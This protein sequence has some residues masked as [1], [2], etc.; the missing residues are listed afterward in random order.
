METIVTKREGVNL[1]RGIIEALKKIIKKDSI[2]YYQ[3]NIID[4]KQAFAIK[5]KGYTVMMEGK[6]DRMN[7]FDFPYGVE[8]LKNNEENRIWMKIKKQ[9]FREEYKGSKETIDRLIKTLKSEPK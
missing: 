6:I 3:T 4:D 2:E 7:G 5:Y 1:I 8:K 9:Q